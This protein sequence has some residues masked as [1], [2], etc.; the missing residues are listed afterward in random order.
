MTQQE[1]FEKALERAHKTGIRI[2]LRGQDADGL[3]AYAV[4]SASSE[5]TLYI[6]THAG[7]VLVC[8]CAAGK[9]GRYCQHRALV[10]SDL[11]ARAGQAK[12]ARIE[13]QAKEAHAPA[14]MKPMPVQSASS[15]DV[16]AA[17]LIRKD[18]GRR[19]FR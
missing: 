6:V 3:D 18:G 9:A 11:M 1:Q 17:P 7:N 14:R 5:G 13:R 4:T 10:R 15:V 8:S 2:V 16:A 19:L 12:A